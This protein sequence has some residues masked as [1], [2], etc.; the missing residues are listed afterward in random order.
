DKAPIESA[1][2]DLKEALKNDNTE[3]IKAKTEALQNAFYA[4]SS[5]VYNQA[6]PNGGAPDFSNMNMGG[7]APESS[8]GNDDGVV[9]ADFTEA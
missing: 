7:A 8:G 3:D 6:N 9:D 1:L 5:K 2:N 4:L